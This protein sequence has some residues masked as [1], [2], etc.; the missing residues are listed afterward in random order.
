[1][2]FDAVES[3]PDCQRFEE[4][5]I[6]VLDS[7]VDTYLDGCVERDAENGEHQMGGYP[8][9]VQGDHMELEAQLV[10]NGVYCGD[11]SGYESEKGKLLAPGA[12]DWRL[13]FQL[14][15]TMNLV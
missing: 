14:V 7:E 13:L 1:V 3:L 15:P 6:N 4:L 2:R 11:A 8:R 5:G 12:R 9:P 10:S